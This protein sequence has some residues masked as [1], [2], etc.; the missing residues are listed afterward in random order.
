MYDI[1]PLL[2]GLIQNINTEHIEFKP[3][4]QFLKETLLHPIGLNLF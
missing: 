2:F 3:T 1:M 4:I